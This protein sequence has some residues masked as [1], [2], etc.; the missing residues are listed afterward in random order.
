M[1]IPQ[2][3]ISLDKKPFVQKRVAIQGWGG[4]GKTTAA[5]TFPNPLVLDIDNS[6]NEANATCAGKELKD[7]HV[8]PFYDG[9]FVGDKN[10]RDFIKNWIE[11]NVRKLEPDQTVILDSWTALQDEFDK[12]WKPV[13]TKRGELDEF[14]FWEAKQDYAREILTFFRQAPCD[15]VVIFHE[16]IETDDK[17]R[18]TGK[19]TP[20]MQGKFVNKL[21]GYFTDW[22][23]AIGV[24][25]RSD[26]NFVKALNLTPEQWQKFLAMP[27]PVAS[28]TIYLWQTTTGNVANCKTKLLGLPTFVPARYNVFANTE[29]FR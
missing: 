12:A 26:A 27:T 9:K 25:R 5:L 24:D 1:F 3:V 6:V 7:I 20:L 19:A 13:Y 28:S 17:G 11:A 29:N 22:F 16:V 8:V 14:A 21:S 23:R 2:D 4:T 18:P 15:V 10:R